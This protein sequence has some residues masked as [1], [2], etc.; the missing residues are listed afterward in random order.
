ME[1]TTAMIVCPHQ[2]LPTPREGGA[3]DSTSIYQPA[4]EDEEA[5]PNY[6]A[7][8]VHNASQLKENNDGTAGAH[9]VNTEGT[10]SFMYS[11]EEETFP[12]PTPSKSHR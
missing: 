2:P 3:S 8:E 12:D 10:Y 4:L 11:T 5:D 9:Y 1:L 7:K 6:T